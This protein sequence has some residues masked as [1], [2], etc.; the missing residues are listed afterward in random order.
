MLEEIF[1]GYPG[2]T[3]ADLEGRRGGP[4]PGPA[5][6]ARQRRP[7]AALRNGSADPA[8]RRP[9]AAAGLQLLARTAQHDATA[10]AERS[11]PEHLRVGRYLAGRGLPPGRRK[12]RRD[13]RRSRLARSNIR[14]A[15]RLAAALVPCGALSGCV[16]VWTRVGQP[17]LEGPAAR[18]TADAPVDRMRLSF[19]QG[20]M[21]VTRDGTAIQFFEARQ[22]AGDKAFRLTKKTPPVD[23]PPAEVAGLILAELRSRPGPAIWRWSR[24]LRQ[25]WLVCPDSGCCC[26]IATIRA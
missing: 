15:K 14:Y 9:S 8:A 25:R 13:A 16:R 18:Y 26:G 5:C 10:R 22:V 11:Q 4:R 3:G 12:R 20:A 23:A 6:L 24:G 2:W 1:R 21:V 17:R 19:D 7:A